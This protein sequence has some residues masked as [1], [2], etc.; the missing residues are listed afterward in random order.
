MSTPIEH[1]LLRDEWTEADRLVL[2]RA[3]EADPELGPAVRRWVALSRA[4]AAQWD[5]GVPSRQALV[6]LACR[7]RFH[8]DDLTDE[9]RVLLDDASAALEASLERHPAV[10]DVLDRIRQEAVA[11]DLAWAQSFESTLDDSHTA[12]DRGPLRR[13]GGSPSGPLRLV[14]LAVAAAAVIA[15]LIVGR[16][17]FDTDMPG[18][19]VTHTAAATMQVVTLEDGSEVRLAPHARLDVLYDEASDERRVRLMGDGFFEV[20]PGP[21]PFRVET[22]NALTTVLGTSFGVRTSNGTEVLLVTGRVSLA[23]NDNPG[24]AVV[25]TPGEQGTLEANA[26]TPSVQTFSTLDGFDWTGLLVFRNTPMAAVAER[27]SEEF[28]VTITVS[29]DLKEAP[30]TGTFESERGSKAIL[31]IIASALGARVIEQDDGSFVVSR[32]ANR[33]R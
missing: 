29:D 10:S 27:L 21:R 26:D 2:Q 1:I 13:T 20:A 33:D 11:F 30:L 28:N 4:A 23:A 16:S 18:P 6:L 3:L 22:S 19:M 14:R 31:D 17:W 15:V 5:E 8:V 9:E 25:L 32:P 12:A 7:E 24:T